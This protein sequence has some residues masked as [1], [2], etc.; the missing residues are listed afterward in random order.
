MEEGKRTSFEEPVEKPSNPRSIAKRV[1]C[2]RWL[3]ILP[4][5][6]VV[7]VLYALFTPNVGSVFDLRQL[8]IDGA[9]VLGDCSS[10][11]RHRYGRWPTLAE[12]VDDFHLESDSLQDLWGN[13]YRLSVDATDRLVVGSDGPDGR[14]G[15]PDDVREERYWRREPGRR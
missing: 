9:R 2:F 15:T 8:S 11:Y 6:F 13:P 3:L 1:L 5:F 14:R 4:W 12:L 7:A 10:V